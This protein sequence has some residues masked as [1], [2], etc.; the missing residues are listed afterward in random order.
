MTGKGK[1]I[2][3]IPDSFN[4]EE[5]AGEFWDSHSTMDY[6]EYL[7]PTDDVFDIRERVFQVQIEEDIF[8]RLQQEAQSHHQSVPVILDQILRKSLAI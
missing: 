5:E 1:R 6:V 8:E 3:P 4:S 2:D 7:Q